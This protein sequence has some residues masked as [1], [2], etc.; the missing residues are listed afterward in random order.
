MTKKKLYGVSERVCIVSLEQ[1]KSHGCT[2]VLFVCFLPQTFPRQET[3]YINDI[4][5]NTR[6]RL[7]TGL[8]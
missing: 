2:C 7:K 8:F 4:H 6:S 3:T 5:I 1:H